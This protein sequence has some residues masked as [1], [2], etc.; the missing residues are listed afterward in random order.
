[1]P[2]QPSAPGRAKTPI[3]LAKVSGQ[4]VSSASIRPLTQ[5]GVDIM[6]TSPAQYGVHGSASLPSF[7]APEACSKSCWAVSRPAMDSAELSAGAHSPPSSTARSPPAAQTKAAPLR[8]SWP[9]N[10]KP[11]KFAGFG[12]SFLRVTAAW[13]N[14]SR[15]VGTSRPDFS[16]RSLR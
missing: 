13:T 6:P 8:Q 14:S 1:M 10:Q 15:L 3:S 12:L 9:G 4:P 7:G 16:K 2:G 5:P 11:E